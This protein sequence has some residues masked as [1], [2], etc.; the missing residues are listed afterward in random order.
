MNRA[1][2]PLEKGIDSNHAIN[3]STSEDFMARNSLIN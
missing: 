3:G 2:Q 1:L